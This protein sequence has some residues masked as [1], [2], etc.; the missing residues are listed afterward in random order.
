MSTGGFEPP[1]WRLW[2]A[3]SNRW[4]TPTFAGGTPI[5]RIAATKY[6]KYSIFLSWAQRA[7]KMLDIVL[8]INKNLREVWECRLQRIQPL[9]PVN[10]LCPRIKDV[11]H[12][13]VKE[14]TGHAIN[15]L[16]ILRL[17]VA[18]VFASKK[19][20]SRKRIS[21]SLSLMKKHSSGQV[22]NPSEGFY[23]SKKY[24][25]DD[26]AF[27]QNIVNLG[28]VY[29]NINFARGSVTV[30]HKAH[31]LE[32]PGSIPGPAIPKQNTPPNG[33]FVLSI[34]GE[35]V[36]PGR[37]GCFT[38]VWELKSGAVPSLSREA[39]SGRSHTI[40]L[41]H[42]EQKYWCEL[43]PI[44]SPAKVKQKVCCNGPFVC[45][46]VSVFLAYDFEPNLIKTIV[47][48]LVIS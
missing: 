43:T 30:A 17:Q 46:I 38:R 44:P 18:S 11:L 32:V 26:T 27:M 47:T 21:R 40:F 9:K 8:H 3:R 41:E 19:L 45:T 16:S 5:R 25:M 12:F 7:W 10:S 1:T 35:R 36:N 4:A 39:S 42:S 34:C 22:K 15:G 6:Q 29:Y 33:C 24:S 37:A 20:I 13:I 31:N 23:F 48:V 14:K 28:I 2:N